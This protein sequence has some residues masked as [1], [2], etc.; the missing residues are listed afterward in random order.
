[1]SR[2]AAKFAK[3]KGICEFHACKKVYDDLCVL[4]VFA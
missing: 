2:K 4:C 3:K 1:M